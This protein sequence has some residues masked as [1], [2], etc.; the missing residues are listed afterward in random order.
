[1]AWCFLHV[2][3]QKSFRF[4][5]AAASN[6]LPKNFATFARLASLQ[7]KTLCTPQIDKIN[8]KRRR[9]TAIFALS[10]AEPP[11]SN[12][13]QTG[14]LETCHFGNEDGVTH[15]KKLQSPRYNSG[16]E[17]WKAFFKT[18]SLCM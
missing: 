6:N 7:I 15:S 11:Y 9:S 17:D 16:V 8:A 14:V 5:I 1:V 10:K 2:S 13:A 12:S 18:K 3:K 4:K